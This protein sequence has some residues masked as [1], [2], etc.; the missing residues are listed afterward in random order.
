[1]DQGAIKAGSKERVEFDLLKNPFVVLRLP[2]SAPKEDIAE[3]FDEG[4]ADGHASDEALR[5]A[6][7]QLLAPKLRLAATLELLADADTQQRD[8]AISTL[9]DSMPLSDL[10][11]FAKDLPVAARTSFLSNIAQLRPSSGILRYFAH[12]LASVDRR[13]LEDKI[14]DIFEE[15]NLPRPTSESVLEAFD[16][17]TR[18]NIKRL[19]S[20]Y[21]DAKSASADMRR[22]LDEGMGS[23]S[24]DQLAAYSSVVTAYLDYASTPISELRRRV[25][26]AVEQ[27]LAN[28]GDQ[29]ALDEIETSLLAWD[30]LSQPAQLLAQQ[31]GR[32]EPQA[33][34]LF[35]YLRSFMIELANEKDAPSAALRI[36]NVCTQVF[37][38]LPRAVSQLKEDLGALQNLVDQEGAK[39]LVQ[40]VEKLRTNLDELVADL[41]GGFD[42]TAIGDAKRLYVLFDQSVKATK[43]TEAAEIPWGL[44][45]ILALDI[46]NDLGEGAASEVLI[47]GLLAHGG[48]GQAPEHMKSAIKTDRQVLRSNA[49]QARLKRAVD[50]KDT[51]AARQA[52]V[53]LA[54][55]ATDDGER[56][57]YQQG[58]ENLDAA[59]RGRMVRWIF[60]AIVIVGAIIAM[61]SQGGGRSSSS[62]ST[63]TYRPPSKPAVTSAPST[64]AVSQAEIKPA[65]YGSAVFSRGNVRYC[66]FES[67]RIGA[68][69]TIMINES[70]R[71]ISLFN[72][73]VDDYNSRCSN[74]RYYPDDLAAVQRE[75]T[76]G[77]AQISADAKTLLQR[78]RMSN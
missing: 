45:R 41:N 53:D 11:A 75:L 71:V 34:E 18:R 29:S 68:I 50:R 77:R 3:A 1:M 37:A 66:Q 33:R 8:L 13:Q 78:W 20:S 31:K 14:G 30:E 63:T 2:L 67:A 65:A 60:W 76:A 12:T 44:V 48:F 19:F 4:M 57:Q 47:A 69:E 21:Q 36:S 61:A 28:T 54:G 62:Y 42:P 43:G 74:Y 9:Q 15:A 24:A 49:A 39:D 38:E 70:N 52:L 40:F 55:L 16:A 56:R 59:K 22:C 64:A 35:Q 51:A 26:A 58:I 10:I 17:S 23:A 5:E 27:F 25:D 32:D 6:R 7:R 72:Q 73:V 46:N